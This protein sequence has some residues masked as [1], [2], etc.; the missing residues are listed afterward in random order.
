[1]NREIK[2]A[3]FDYEL[4][5]ERIAKF[6]LPERDSSKLLLY[7][8]GV[9]CES[10]FSQIADHLPK[11][12]LMVF[13]NTKV[14]RARLFFF[15][16]TG[17][18][19]E[20]F[21]LEPHAPA[22][23]ERSLSSHNECSWSCIIGNAKKWKSGLL[24]TE[25][26]HNGSTE[27]V[28]AERE[29]DD[30]VRFRWTGD[31]AFGELLE[32][33]GKIPIPPY[34]NRESEESDYQRYQTTYSKFEGS[35]AAPTAGLHFSAATFQ[36]LEQQG[37]DTAEITLHV[38]A[39][40]F[41]PVKSEN[42]AEHHMHAEHF[43]VNLDTL[44]KIISYNKVVCVGTTAVRTL[45]SLTVLGY[46]VL[47]NGAPD[48]ERV[49]GQ[50][51][52]YDIPSEMS[53]DV[54]IGALADYLSAHGVERVSVSTAIMIT[55]GYVFRVVDGIVTNFHQPRSTLLLLISALVGDEWR[56]IYDFA[57]CHDFR[58]LSYG[59]SS[60]LEG[61]V[62]RHDRNLVKVNHQSPQ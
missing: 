34:L 13:N 59:D 62:L 20:I 26:D 10:L 18:K 14:I 48:F 36:S 47:K 1:M 60:Y 38:G 55:P 24:T 33:L 51:E 44:R 19:I 25:F 5:E 45:E 29:G 41:L 58:F 23:Y 61:A 54:L 57:L 49:I 2:I 40:T 42:A 46:R 17:A 3:A 31:L 52:A 4:P 8:D 32:H 39:G 28:T 12:A 15:K 27:E 30:V 53:K 37:I 50:W 22:D 6:P 43:L 7:K 11:G 35:V 16:E 56:N 9:I 21:C